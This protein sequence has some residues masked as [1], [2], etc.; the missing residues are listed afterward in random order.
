MSLFLLF[1]LMEIPETNIILGS[2]YRCLGEAKKDRV[3][4]SGG[5][6]CRK[7]ACNKWELG[8]CVPPDLARCL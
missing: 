8:E 2:G 3:V 5:S 4:G 6:Q 7:R 1:I